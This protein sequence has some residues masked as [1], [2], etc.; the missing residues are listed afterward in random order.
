MRCVYHDGLRYH[1]VEEITDVRAV[2]LGD[3][4]RVLRIEGVADGVPFRD[5][6]ASE[7]RVYPD[8]GDGVG[9]DADRARCVALAAEARALYERRE[10]EKAAWYAAPEGQRYLRLIGQADD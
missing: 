2:R 4:R 3:G 8:P 5:S 1:Q 9:R 10:A 6:L 7:F